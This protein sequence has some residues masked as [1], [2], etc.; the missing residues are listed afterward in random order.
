MIDGNL[1][2]INEGDES[3]SFDNPRSP[4]KRLI[5]EL[6]ATPSSRVRSHPLGYQGFGMEV[7]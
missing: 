2:K 4:E 7:K 3:E 1:E 5:G 6:I